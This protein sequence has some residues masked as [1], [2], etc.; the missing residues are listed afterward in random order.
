MSVKE[1]IIKILKEIVPDFLDS[2]LTIP[3]NSLMGD[4]A[5]ACF[6]YAKQSKKS[7]LDFAKELKEKID[8]LTNK[9]IIVKAEISGPYVNIFIN[10]EK[11]I[12]DVISDIQR[13][14]DKFGSEDKKDKTIVIDYSGPNVAKNMGIHNLRSTIIG[15]SLY[16]SYKFLGYKTV[17]VNHLGD[18]GTQFGKLIWASEKWSNPNELQEKGILFLNELYVRY[19]KLCDDLKLEGKEKEVEQMEEE[20]RLWFKKIEDN[21]ER[22]IMWWKIFID[23]SLLEY[24]SIYKRL[25]ISFDEVKG[26]SYYIPYIDSALKT[27]EE[28][29]LTTI[30]DGALVVKFD[31]KEKMPPCLLKKSDGATLYGTRDIAAGMYRLKTY[32]PTKVLYL[33]D[34]AQGFH[35]KQWFKVMELLDAKNKEIFVHVDFGRLSFPDSDMST[36]K[37]NIVPLKEVLDKSSNKALSIIQEKSPDLKNKEDIAEI[38]GIGAIIFGDLSNDRLNNI[39]FEWDKVLDFQ[40]ETAPYIQYTYARIKSI[41]RKE[42]AKIEKKFDSKFLTE[43]SEYDLVKKLSDFNSVLNQVILNNKPSI[44]CRYLIDLCQMFN[45]YYDNVTILK[46]YD[47]VKNARLIFILQITTV[48]KNGMHILGINVPERM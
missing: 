35:F 37:G 30:D 33:T 43:K 46:A 29:K 44:L 21:N 31:E 14:K 7:P 15:Q 16:N 32:N 4:Y 10:R 25:D 3:P 8:A 9:N 34:I 28:H 1:N 38:V 2:T 40:G 41:L 23:I 48:I 47:D 22:A 5:I 17:G 20:S 12:H 42:D 11:F 45:K 18:W 39:V 36:R 13:Q 19:H 27:L 26:E 24:N 6:V